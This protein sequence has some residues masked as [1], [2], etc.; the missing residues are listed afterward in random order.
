ML[1]KTQT[2]LVFV[3]IHALG[4]AAPVLPPEGIAA[5]PATPVRKRKGD[6]P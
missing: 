5:L 2:R 1:H 6:R 3:L 4:A